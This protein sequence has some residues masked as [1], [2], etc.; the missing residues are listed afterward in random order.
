MLPADFKTPIWWM[1]NWCIV[2]QWIPGNRSRDA[3]TNQQS[4]STSLHVPR[5]HSPHHHHFWHHPW[6]QVLWPML[7]VLSPRHKSLVSPRPGRGNHFLTLNPCMFLVIRCPLYCH[8]FHLSCLELDTAFCCYIPSA[9][10]LYVYRDCPLL[11]T[12]I[13]DVCSS[14]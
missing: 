3:P 14:W 1:L 10:R 13:T 2:L 5:K 8:V 12:V 11:T 4:F 7:I 6:I 9:S